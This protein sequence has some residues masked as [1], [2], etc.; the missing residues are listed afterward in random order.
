MEKSTLKAI[1][2]IV[3][4]YR[5]AKG[6]T[7]EQLAE[8]TGTTFSYVGS[9]ERGERNMSIMTLERIARA[10]HV[11]FFE[12]LQIGKNK[13]LIEINALLLEQDDFDRERA[14]NI[15]KELFKKR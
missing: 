9:L 11:D 15:L 6:M 14:I 3:R 4:E 12:F 5:K 8:L 10:F 7:Q 1:G 13:T 2:Q